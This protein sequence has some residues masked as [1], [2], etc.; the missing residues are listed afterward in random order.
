MTGREAD[1]L[2]ER[3]EGLLFREFGI[4]LDDEDNDDIGDIIL[5]HDKR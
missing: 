3:I 4:L 5:K 2:H 1:D